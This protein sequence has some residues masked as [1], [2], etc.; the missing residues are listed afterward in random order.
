M[1]KMASK[2]PIEQSHDA[3]SKS[4]QDIPGTPRRSR[5][6]KGEG[7]FRLDSPGAPPRTPQTTQTPRAPR[8]PRT[9]RTPR[10]S[11]TLQTPRFIQSPI[12]ANQGTTNGSG[13]TDMAQPL[14]FVMEA[15]A[16]S[17]TSQAAYIGGSTQFNIGKN[18]T[19][20]NIGKES[21]RPSIGDESPRPK[22]ASEES[23]L[24]PFCDNTDGEPFDSPFWLRRLGSNRTE[25]PMIWVSGNDYMRTPT[26]KNSR[27]SRNLSTPQFA[28]RIRTLTAD[29][30]EQFNSSTLQMCMPDSPHTQSDQWRGSNARINKEAAFAMILNYIREQQLSLPA[31][32]EKL[33]NSQ[34]ENIKRWTHQ[35]YH[36]DG[37]RR[38]IKIWSQ[39][40]RK[41]KEWDAPFV[42]SAVD[43]VVSRTKRE[44]DRL[45]NGVVGDD[46]PHPAYR[47][48]H[49]RMS[50]ENIDK[51]LRNGFLDSYAGEASFLTRLLD[52]ML[53]KGNG[54][55][56]GDGST[57]V[58]EGNNN[59]ND[60]ENDTESNSDNSDNSGDNDI[61][62]NGDNTVNNGSDNIGN[63]DEET[64]GSA[65]PAR[66]RGRKPSSVRGCISAM[67][68][69]LRSQQCNAFQMVMGIYL[70]CL[71]APRRVLETLSALGLCV[72]YDQIHRALKALT[73]DAQERVKV[74]VLNNDF[75]IVY[76]NIN[77]ATR[78]HHQRVGK[79]DTFDNGTAATVILIPD[80]S[81]LGSSRSAEIPRSSP[82]VCFRV[83]RPE[84]SASIFFPTSTDRTMTRAACRTHLS[85]AISQFLPR[86]PSVCVI[87]M[88]AIDVL[89]VV[90]TKTFPLPT[91]KIDES[92]IAGNLAV[93]ENITKIDLG[94]SDEWFS[95]TTRDI[96]VAGDQMTV[97]RLLSLK[98]HR[99]VES[100]PFGSLGWV[101]PTFQLFHLQMT[102]CSTIYKTHL[103]ADANTPGSLASFIS[104]LA[105]KGF[106]TDKPEYKPTSELLKIVFDAMSM[107]LWEDLHTSVESDMTRFVDLVIYA[108]ASLQH[109]NPL[110]NGR[111]CTPADINALLFLRD[112]IVFIELSA[113]IKAGD[114]GRIRCVLPTVALMMHGGGNSK[115]AL[116]LLRFSPRH[117][118]PVD[119]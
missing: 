41:I 89:K 109:A 114:L 65:T 51:I 22:H 25:T 38:V 68:M 49:N 79:R 6:T 48:P 39:K 18:S 84:P 47:F 91:M 113:A 116:E 85:T 69:F 102:L 61:D 97:S 58:N 27:R 112:M 118:P 24:D 95:K 19:P 111:P 13:A 30:E 108:I 57:R 20:P 71:G 14:P 78:H 82:M 21:P 26:R 72:S 16:L 45:K 52:G 46:G 15:Q 115:Y 60:S 110:L 2:R 28:D 54:T 76:D 3:L 98:V 117:A 55:N 59:G 4:D 99:M 104:L 100:D 67:L 83:D 37:P 35:F 63:N 101:H 10:T 90:K 42:N 107:V 77:I 119:A 29:M 86:S 81:N 32:F 62:S 87:P 31:F 106:N 40:L 36:K 23:L 74:A 73:K 1:T 75:Y 94:L 11:Q 88:P 17:P 56:S 5:S 12:V 96:I 8:A 93:L 64:V 7:R 34:D 105:S 9:P 53:S 44:L 33:F 50:E 92:T 43:V 103:G 80:S 70:H 66:R